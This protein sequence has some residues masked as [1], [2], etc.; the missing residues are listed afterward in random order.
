MAGTDTAWRV[1]SNSNTVGTGEQQDGAVW[2]AER[3]RGGADWPQTFQGRTFPSAAPVQCSTHRSTYRQTCN[4]V[5]DC[6]R[7]HSTQ[8][9]PSTRCRCAS[10]VPRCLAPS[11]TCGPVA[12]QLRLG[13]APAAVTRRPPCRRCLP[14]PRPRQQRRL[15]HQ[16]S[17]RA[18]TGGPP[19]PKHH[20]QQRQD[21]LSCPE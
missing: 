21:A 2:L 4:N 6:D 9:L 15:P 3:L 5:P 18:A 20:L 14:P 7:R 1:A 12:P 19:L 11:A 17:S 8:P 13:T 10:R 16:N